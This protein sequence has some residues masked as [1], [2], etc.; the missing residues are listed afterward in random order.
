MTVTRQNQFPELVIKRTPANARSDLDVFSKAE[1][2]SQISLI[3]LSGYTP[4]TTTSSISG[5]LDNRI[6]IIESQ[7]P[8]ISGSLDSLETLVTDISGALTIDIDNVLSELTLLELD[9]IKIIEVTS[10][11]EGAPSGANWFTVS[12]SGSNYKLPVWI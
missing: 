2:T 5:G 12:I 7:I 10:A 4:L 3:D 1:V 6:D 11:P 9:S 8:A